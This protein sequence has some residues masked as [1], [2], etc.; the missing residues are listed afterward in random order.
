MNG[1][2]VFSR[3]IGIDYS[4]AETPVSSLSGKANPQ[5]VALAS[6]CTI[7]HSWSSPFWPFDAWLS[8]D[9]LLGF[10]FL[11]PA[12]SDH[13]SQNADGPLSLFEPCGRADST[14]KG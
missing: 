10:P 14:H 9:L 4:G 2:P 3:Y 7:A 12:Y 8:A 11:L 1:F 5:R 6:I 13:R